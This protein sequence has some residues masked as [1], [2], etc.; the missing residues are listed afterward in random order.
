MIS[1]IVI[2]CD[3]GNEEFFPFE[4]KEGESDDVGL[5]RIYT[6]T[7]CG[8]QLRL[9]QTSDRWRAARAQRPVAEKATG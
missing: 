6:C 5:R 1:D 4:F 9:Y 3:C 8:E 2:A 7:R